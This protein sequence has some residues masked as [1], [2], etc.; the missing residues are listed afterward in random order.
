MYRIIN[1]VI[2]LI[3]T[4]CTSISPIETPKKL[5][6]T[7]GITETPKPKTQFLA[8][9]DSYT[10]GQGV[11]EEDRWPEQLA[12]FLNEQGFDTQVTVIARTGWTTEDLLDAISAQSLLEEYDMVSLLIGVNDQYRGGDLEN[13]RSNFRDLLEEAITLAGNDPR[14]VII[15]SIPDWE[16][17]PFANQTI[18]SQPLRQFSID[19]FN[20]I[21]LEEAQAYDVRYVNITPISR[22]VTKDN[23]LLAP[24]GL[25]PSGK[26]YALWVKEIMPQ[27]LNILEN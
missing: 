26:M 20:Q 24:D 14:N 3:L 22:Q 10:I 27:V 15:L 23:M 18:P 4:S 19:D 6:Q 12:V 8:L 5:T 1:L 11:P 17:T 25:H 9:G 13:Y 16:V 2:I 21:N 7:T